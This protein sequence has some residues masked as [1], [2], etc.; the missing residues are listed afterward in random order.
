METP[1]YRELFDSA[2][3]EY[4]DEYEYIIHLA[5]LSHFQET[6]NIICDV[7]IDSNTSN[8]VQEVHTT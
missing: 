3:K 5:C 8:E 6:A 4:P 1:E 2:K 7:I